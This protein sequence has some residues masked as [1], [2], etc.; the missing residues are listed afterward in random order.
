MKGNSEITV[1]EWSRSV[2]NDSLAKNF[3]LR[4]LAGGGGS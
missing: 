2:L 4:L 3:S 1:Q